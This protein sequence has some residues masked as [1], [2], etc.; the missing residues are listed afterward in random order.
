MVGK[1]FEKLV[2]NRI[3]DH[4]EKCGLFSNFQNG[5]RYSRSTA[6]LLTV[7]F[8]RM[9]TAFNRS[10][11]T[12]PVAHDFSVTIP[13]SYKD[14]YV[15]SFFPPTARFWNSLPTEC[16]PLTYDLS[17]CKSRINRLLL[18]VGSY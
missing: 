14:V 10:G 16:F 8:D 3:V 6:D 11:A 17:S 9:G 4:L 7:V 18:T 2:N 13:R 1:V 15:N 12:R 5:F